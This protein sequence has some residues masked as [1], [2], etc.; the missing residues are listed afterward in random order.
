MQA[1]Y[2]ALRST[3]VQNLL[4]LAAINA[5]Q[6]AKISDKEIDAKISK[7]IRSPDS[8]VSL[9]AMEVHQRREAARKEAQAAGETPD[10]RSAVEECFSTEGIY[11]APVVARGWADYVLSAP[12]FELWASFLK[13]RFPELWDKY[14]QPLLSRAECFKADTEER[15]R[16]KLFDELGER[17]ELTDDQ[18]RSA[19][20]IKG[21]ATNAA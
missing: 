8:T 19:I 4:E 21:M 7:L 20:R 11:A 5:P 3:A 13:K 14:R 9:K 10:Y 17:A 18:F 16:L 2:T 1:G 6:D 15:R 12:Y